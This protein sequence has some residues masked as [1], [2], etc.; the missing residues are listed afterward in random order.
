MLGSR[1]AARWPALAALA[2]SALVFWRTAYPGI[3]WWDSAQYSLAAGTLG[4]AGPPG[5]LLLTLLGW[6]V[7]HLHLSASPAHDLNLFA[8]LLAA[9]TVA[10]VAAVALRL[11]RLTSE[12]EQG[13]SMIVGAGIALGAL[14]FAF[15]PTLWEYATQFTPYVLTALFTGLLLWTLVCWWEATDDPDGWRW[16]ALLGFLF[17]LD[18]SVHRTNALLVPGALAWIL[19][20]KPQTLIAPKVIAGA[21]AGLALG[22]AVQLLLIPT[23]RVT[24]SPLIWNGTPNWH[25][26]WSYVTIQRLGGGFLV[27]FFP[28]K[29]ALWSVQAADFVRVLGANFFHWKGP[30]GPLGLLP[31]LAALY[32][33]VLLWRSN[34][35]LGIAITL[36]LVIQAVMTVLFFNI[37]ANFF[38]TLDRHYLPVCVT[39][40][41]LAAYGL[42]GLLVATLRASPKGWRLIPLAAGILALVAPGAQLLDNWTALDASQCH[43]AADYALNVLRSLPRNAIYFTVGDNDT[44]P[45]LYMQA[46]EGVRRDVTVVNLSVAE[47]PEYAGELLRHEPSFPLDPA[48]RDS[49]PGPKTIPVEGTAASLDLPEGVRPPTELAVNV[50]PQYGAAMLPAEVTLLDLVRTNRWR[51]PLAFA[52]TGTRASMTWLGPYGRLDGLYYRVVPT[53]DPAPNLPLL[54]GNLLGVASYRGYADSSVLL[55]PVSSRAIAVQYYLGFAELLRTEKKAGDTQQCRRDTEVLLAAIP[56]ARLALPKDFQKQ[57]LPECGGGSR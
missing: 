1:T 22:L 8:G 26:L 23:S 30:V 7:A 50:K 53:P 57:L 11:T 42:G 33:L 36:L 15:G 43:F 27:Q 40:A 10:L 21:A 47:M 38:R 13:P 31:G 49:T 54:R 16:L 9:L 55:D 17:G 56:P 34:R 52:G 29:A 2:L 4:N 41:V 20:R 14:A 28:R 37:P 19:C 51:R 39:I 44:F 24:H 35:R 45:L 48:A 12:P 46:M 25:E 18:V 5:S 6:P 32:G 3:N